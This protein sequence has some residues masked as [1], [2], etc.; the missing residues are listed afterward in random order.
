VGRGGEEEGEVEGG[1]VEVDGGGG[2]AEEEC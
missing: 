1:G 2:E